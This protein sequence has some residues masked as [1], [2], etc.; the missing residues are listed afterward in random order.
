VSYDFNSLIQKDRQERRQQ[1]FNKTF[2]DY[3]QIVKDDPQVTML[4]HERMYR[5]ITAAGV[6]TI[7]TEEHPVCGDYMETQ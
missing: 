1:Q 4:A 7:K 3:L 2:L 5:L 6:K